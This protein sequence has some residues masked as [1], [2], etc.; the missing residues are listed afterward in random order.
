MQ[1]N[2]RIRSTDTPGLCCGEP[3]LVEEDGIPAAEQPEPGGWATPGPPLVLERLPVHGGQDQLDVPCPG[4][5]R[6]ASRL[7]APA[8]LSPP[9]L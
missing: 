1:D 7:V 4:R 5:P 6:R 9:T 3:L 8:V 2:D